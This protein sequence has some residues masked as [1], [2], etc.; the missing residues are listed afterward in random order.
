MFK[1]TV[2]NNF[3]CPFSI[4]PLGV[5]FCSAVVQAIISA[6]NV[7]YAQAIHVL[8]ISATCKTS[9][10]TVYELFRDLQT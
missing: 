6:G 2:N 3:N 9:I 4:S 7:L 5:D 10:I 1:L 8:C